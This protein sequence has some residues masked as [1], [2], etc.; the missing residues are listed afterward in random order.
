MRGSILNRHIAP[1]IGDGPKLTLGFEMCRPREGQSKDEGELVASK[2][3]ISDVS[4]IFNSFVLR[5]EPGFFQFLS[6]R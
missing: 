1:I 5:V 3:L 6:I 4:G 2:Q